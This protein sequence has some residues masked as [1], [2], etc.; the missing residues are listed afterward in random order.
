M[1]KDFYLRS[2]AFI[3]GLVYAFFCLT[4]EMARTNLR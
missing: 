1:G 2:F 4:R 3:C